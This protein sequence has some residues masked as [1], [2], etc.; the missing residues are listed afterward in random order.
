MKLKTDA[1]VLRDYKIE[2]DRILTLLSRELGV[3]TA[4]AGGANRMRSRLSG[5]TELLCYSSFV[6]FKNKERHSV[7]NADSI[8]TFFGLRKVVEDLALAS[9]FAELAAELAGPQDAEACLRL[10][11]NTLHYLEK[12]SRSRALLKPLYELRL[13][14]LAG[15]MPSLVACGDCARYEADSMLFFPSRGDILCPDCT[16]KREILPAGGV[17]IPPGVLA[18]MRHIIYV[19]LDKLY[20]F[21]LSEEGLKRLGQASE[22][23]VKYQLDRTFP[24]LEFYH[25]LDPNEK[26][27]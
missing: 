9:Y 2:D 15:Y 20:T 24:A 18:A 1:I 22:D 25:S 23:Y 26:Q 21:T 5:S 16:A 13:L 14:T 12:G 4:Y 10:L 11:L 19:E 3:V 17:H 6:L 8:R 27:A 7:D